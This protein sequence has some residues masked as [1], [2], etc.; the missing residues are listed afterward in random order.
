[1]SP[2][3]SELDEIPDKEFKRAIIKYVQRNQRAHKYYCEWI[4]KEYKKLN[5]T[6]TPTWDM[7]AGFSKE[8]E[9]ETKTNELKYW[10][11]KIQ[12]VKYKLLWKDLSKNELWRG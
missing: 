8:R 6:G 12:Q 7:E 5:E 11:W 10:K 3:D 2:S 1:M 4:T 9:R